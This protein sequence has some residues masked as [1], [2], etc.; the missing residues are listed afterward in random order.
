MC[1][2]QLDL[3]QTTLYIITC[4][5]L[6]RTTVIMW[7]ALTAIPRRARVAPHPSK[8]RR[9]KV[10]LQQKQMFNSRIAPWRETLWP[11]QCSCT[12]FVSESPAFFNSSPFKVL[13]PQP[14]KFLKGLLPVKE[15]NKAK[16]ALEARPLLGQ[17]VMRT[18]FDSQINQI[19]HFHFT[20]SLITSND[21]TTTP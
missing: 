7:T 15:E 6:S 14:A 13:S 4:V 20:L 21:L 8:A 3:N 1:C 17:E 5:L 11:P 19:P 18:V 16:K 2:I 9:I 12:G 10:W